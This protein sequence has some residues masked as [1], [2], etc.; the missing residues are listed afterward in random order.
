MV[1]VTAQLTTLNVIAG[2]AKIKTC[3]QQGTQRWFS[4][5]KCIENTFQA[6]QST[7]T[8]LEMHSKRGYKICIDCSVI[9][10]GN[11]SRF[12]EDQGYSIIFPKILD[13]III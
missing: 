10:L 12:A 1:C 13:A 3:V 2:M 11:L 7:F 8:S 9:L 4:L 5:H 6:I